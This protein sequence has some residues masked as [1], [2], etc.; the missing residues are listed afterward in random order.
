MQHYD[1]YHMVLESIHIK[2]MNLKY[3][4]LDACY[5]NENE[6]RTVRV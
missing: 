6:I 2:H 1:I 3:V 5:A 4:L